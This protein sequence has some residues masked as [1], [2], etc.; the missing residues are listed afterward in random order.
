M[1]KIA[2]V[3]CLLV[4]LWTYPVFADSVT[5]INDGTQIVTEVFRFATY[6]DNMVGMWV[7]AYSSSFLTGK[8]TA[9]WGP[10]G[11][12]AGKAEGTGWSLKESGHTFRS[13]WTLS[14]GDLTITQLTIDGFPGSTVFDRTKDKN[15]DIFGTPDSEEG[16]D[17]RRITPNPN[18]P[19][20]VV[21]ATYE[22]HVGVGVIDP[23]DDLYRS[24]HLVFN[25]EDGFKGT[26]TYL[27]DT[28]NARVPA[29]I[30]EPA[31]M[32]LLGT[33]LLGIWVYGR[34]RFK[35]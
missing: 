30:P 29:G 26:M 35:K 21:D 33:G 14:T 23:Y 2:G 11:L 22:G 20:L 16:K 5:A 24:L 17:F 10:D 25:D 28:D 13:P 31:T 15:D 34:R 3:I 4:L 7:T 9:I 27:S 6:G 19:G 8:E 18:L 32:L 12:G 1:K